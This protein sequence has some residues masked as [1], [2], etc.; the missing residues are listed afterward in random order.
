MDHAVVECQYAVYSR[1]RLPLC[2]TSCPAC[3]ALEYREQPWNITQFH[4]LN[5][6]KHFI[7]THDWHDVTFCTLIKNMCWPIVVMCMLD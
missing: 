6:I 5:A 1:D 4:S 3:T 2:K 7:L